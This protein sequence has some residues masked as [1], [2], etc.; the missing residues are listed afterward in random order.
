[1]P[2]T[3]FRELFAMSLRAGMNAVQEKIRL[4]REA[5]AEV[6]T[7]QR[8][9]DDRRRAEV[10]QQLAESAQRNAERLA[11]IERLR[12]KLALP[13]DIEQHFGRRRQ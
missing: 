11:E 8:A 5:R 7:R 1:M 13:I 2:P 12:A 3:I 4:R 10:E 6:E 9:E